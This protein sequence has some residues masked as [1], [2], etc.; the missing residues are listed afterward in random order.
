M[1]ADRAPMITVHEF[2]GNDHRRAID[3]AGMVAADPELADKK[4]T[5]GG[6]QSRLK[7]WLESPRP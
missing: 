2:I 4:L 1:S 3:V 5:E 6:W 7:A